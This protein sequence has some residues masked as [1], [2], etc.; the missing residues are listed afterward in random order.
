MFYIHLL[1]GDMVALRGLDYGWKVFEL[2]ELESCAVLFISLCS[3]CLVYNSFLFLCF[4]N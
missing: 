1:K 2:E 4:Q 3:M